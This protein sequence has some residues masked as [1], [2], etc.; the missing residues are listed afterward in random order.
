M[1]ERYRASRVCS[2]ESRRKGRRD[3]PASVCSPIVARTVWTWLPPLSCC[4]ARLTY[5]PRFVLPLAATGRSMWEFA[6]LRRRKVPLTGH[7]SH[8]DLGVRE[9]LSG[10]G[11]VARP[12]IENVEYSVTTSTLSADP[13]RQGLVPGIKI[14][15]GEEEV[16]VLNVHTVQI[17]AARGSYITAAKLA[18]DFSEPAR[19]YG[20]VLQ[21]L[22]SSAHTID[23]RVQLSVVDASSDS[24]VLKRG[25]SCDLSP[26][27]DGVGY[28]IVDR[29]QSGRRPPKGANGGQKDRDQ[30]C[31][32]GCCG[33][34]CW[35]VNQANE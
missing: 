20:Q 6:F 32:G 12:A 23:C 22:P 16:P 9:K 18:L 29:Q 21:T 27:S 7:G 35:R 8:S 17:R 30:R 26:L 13:S 10:P 4:V 19:I 15:I 24:D 3:R 5:S 1:R 25:I 14:Q 33:P 34:R 2:A 28:S 31:R 11:G